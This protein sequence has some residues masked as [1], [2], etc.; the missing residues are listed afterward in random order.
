MS[1]RESL[2]MGVKQYAVFSLLPFDFSLSPSFDHLVSTIFSNL[3]GMGNDN[4]EV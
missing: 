2:R 3:C 1:L 4:H